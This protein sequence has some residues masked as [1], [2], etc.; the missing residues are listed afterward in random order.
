MGKAWS[1]AGPVSFVIYRLT[2]L[3]FTFNLPLFSALSRCSYLS[4]QVPRLSLHGI[5]QT[6]GT[7]E[8]FAANIGGRMIGTGGALITTRLA[9]AMPG[10]SASEQL[11][12]AAGIVGVSSFL[13]ALVASSRLPEPEGTHLPE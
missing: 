5:I 3:S 11:A 7:G 9:A 12:F 6:R 1:C 2:V 10:A 4:K 8:S 13:I